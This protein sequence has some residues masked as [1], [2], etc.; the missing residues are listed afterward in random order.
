MALC[1][2]VN[3][4]ANLQALQHLEIENKILETKLNARN[5]ETLDPEKLQEECERANG[6]ERRV[7]ALEEELREMRDDMAGLRKANQN[8]LQEISALKIQLSCEDRRL[9]L[10]AQ[11][12][13]Q[14]K[15]QLLFQKL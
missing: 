12:R 2:G 8:Q 3:A 15:K 7:Q 10:L 6:A 14:E 11:E 13:A 1:P 4:V 9:A 5:K